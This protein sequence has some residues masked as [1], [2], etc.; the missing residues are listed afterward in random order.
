MQPLSLLSLSYLSD[1]LIM[2]YSSSALW[3]GV[4]PGCAPVVRQID[5]SAQGGGG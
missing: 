4:P 1:W 2:I 3:H 5:I